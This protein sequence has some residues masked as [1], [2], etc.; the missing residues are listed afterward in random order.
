LRNKDAELKKQYTKLFLILLLQA[1]LIRSSNA[2]QPVMDMAPRWEDGYGFQVRQEYFTS[3]KLLNKTNTVS[4]DSATEQIINKTWFEGVYT[5]KR[6]IRTSF[7]LPY[8]SQK[9]TNKENGTNVERKGNGVSDLTLGLLLKSYTNL[10]EITWNWAI[11]PSI[12]I[13]TGSTSAEFP[14]GDGSYDFGVSFSTSIETAY[15]FQLYDLF[16]WKNGKGKR[17]ADEGDEIG[18]DINVGIHPYHNNL[19][20]QG[21][22]LFWDV[23]ARHQNKGQQI[24]KKTGGTKLYTGPVA[25]FYRKNWMTRLE[26][27]FP[28]Y[29]KTYGI[30]FSRGNK[31]S[32]GTGVTF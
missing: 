27:S 29:E 1:I 14:V 3:D 12:R 5:F 24:N 32:L 11:T 15:V 4:T 19:K 22:F 16:Y 26:Y 21:I 7:K 10:G 13:P 17:G 2:H 28:A 6:W 25:M 20:N 9:K 31:V 23:S 18:L 8:I 30:Q